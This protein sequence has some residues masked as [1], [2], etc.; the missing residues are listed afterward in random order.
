MGILILFTAQILSSFMGIY[1]ETTYLKH[2]SNWR[3]GL[4]YTVTPTTPTLRKS[5]LGGVA[6]PLHPLLHPLPPTYNPRLLRPPQLYN[7]THPSSAARTTALPHS[8]PPTH[9]LSRRQRH[10]AVS[11]CARGKPSQRHL[12]GIDHRYYP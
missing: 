9:L 11:V 1:L 10:D 8:Y 6:L 4:F 3:E 12:N 2:G 5:N 7:T